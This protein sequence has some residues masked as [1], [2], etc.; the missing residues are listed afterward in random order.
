MHN[1][2][3]GVERFLTIVGVCIIL[4]WAVA[5]GLFVWDYWK[6]RKK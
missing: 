2:F 4:S 5:I 1:P 6:R 3:Y